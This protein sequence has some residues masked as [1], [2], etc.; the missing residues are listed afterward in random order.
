MREAV[1]KL[2]ANH[3]VPDV[4]GQEKQTFQTDPKPRVAVLLVSRSNENARGC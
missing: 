4:P 3:F 2:K 1:S